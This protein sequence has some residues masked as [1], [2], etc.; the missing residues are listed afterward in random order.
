MTHF[1]LH[2]ALYAKFVCIHL[3]IC[4]IA[5]SSELSKQREFDA[6]ISLLGQQVLPDVVKSVYSS[7]VVNNF[8]T[9]SNSQHTT[10]L[11][12]YALSRRP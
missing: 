6:Y 5:Q 9:C 2:L 7:A 4:Q 1:I 12:F 10:G 3:Y 11:S 8:S